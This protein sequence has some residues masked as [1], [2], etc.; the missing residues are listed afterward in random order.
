[1]TKGPHRLV[2]DSYL[3]S[4]SG[5]VLQGAGREWKRK[6]QELQTLSEALRLAAE[7][8]EL[9]IGEQTLTGPAV[10]AGMEESSTSMS[11]KA[12]QLTAAGEALVVVGQQ[13]SD[14]RDARDS[15]AELGE[16]PSPYQAPAGT[17]GVKPTPEELKAQADASQARQNERSA[18][19]SQYEKQE[20]TSLALTKQL[21][22]AFIGAIPPMQEI[23]GQ[24]DPTEPPPNVPSGPGGTYLPGT[25]AP[26]PTGGGTGGR[27]GSD[28]SDGKQS[29]LLWEPADGG[30]DGVKDPGT[31]HG[32]STT[33]GCNLNPQ[34]NP[35]TT[36]T[37]HV[38]HPTHV[39]ETPTTTV[40]G[41]TQSGVT[42]QQTGSF[43][44]APAA[45]GSASGSTAAALGAA[46]AAGGAG[47]LAGAMRPGAVS[48]S[49]AAGSAPAR[50]I[51]ST[52][53]TGSAG[54]L[55]RSAGSSAAARSG[56]TTGSPASRSAGSAAGRSGAAGRGAA[57]GSTSGSRSGSS[58]ARGTGS[59]GGRGGRKG[60]REKTTDRD[61]LVYE[62]D[63]LGDDDVAPGVLD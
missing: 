2:L 27:D 39:T 20:A 56:A 57:S 18:W 51:G 21:D 40:S 60:E 37:T 11:L 44:S 15:M 31:D 42:Y 48:S 7:Q 45:S 28:G 61:G 22:A 1:M 55:S 14:A 23:H 9:R 29:G 32:P 12:E 35:T 41:H 30:K 19:Q 46:G 5:G 38:T 25:Q 8:A 13:V 26:I 10:R 59:A 52:A 24:K 63:W 33:I 54:A 53:R 43:G 49:S 62:Q 36:T 16:K 58:G 17:P 50:A 34:P 4:A 6:A 3:D 47:G